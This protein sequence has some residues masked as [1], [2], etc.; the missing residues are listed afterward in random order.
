MVATASEVSRQILSCAHVEAENA[1]N[2]VGLVKLMGRDAGF[3]AAVATLASQEVNFCLISEIPIV[4]DG[5]NGF[6]ENLRKAA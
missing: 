6:L 3:I 4:L 2:G 1:Y 5:S